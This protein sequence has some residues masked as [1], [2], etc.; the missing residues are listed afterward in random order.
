MRNGD[1]DFTGYMFESLDWFSVPNRTYEKVTYR[2]AKGDEDQCPYKDRT[3]GHVLDYVA[4][5]P[6]L[7]VASSPIYSQRHITFIAT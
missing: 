2:P 3:G 1:A 7:P 4:F 6:K 5:L